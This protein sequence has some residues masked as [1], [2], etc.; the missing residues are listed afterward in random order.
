MTAAELNPELR[1]L[2]DERLDAIDRILATAQ[3]TWSERRSIVGEVE[4]QVFELLSR[5][6]QI[7]V[8]EDVL[9]VIDSLDP[10]E[11][12]IPEELRRPVGDTSAQPVAPAANPAAA[13]WSQL[14]RQVVDLVTRIIPKI[15][16]AI[17]LVVVNGIVVV[18]IAA[19]GGLIPWLVTLTGLAWLNYTGVQKFR[20]WS[21]TRHGNLIDDMRHCLATWLMPKNG[22]QT[23]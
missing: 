12:Y 20:A 14:P 1:K 19:S 6:S 8:L 5:R 2:I 17:A 23:T 3:I 18:I 13:N 11:S 9:V 22:T 15:A 16:G 10:P 4:T 21:G 7:P